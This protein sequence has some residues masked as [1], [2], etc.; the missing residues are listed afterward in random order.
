LI[1]VPPLENKYLPYD[2]GRY[3]PT[4]AE[5]AITVGTCMGM[6]LLYVLFAKFVPMI[7]IWELKGPKHAEPLADQ[8]Q[9]AVSLT[10]VR[11]GS[12]IPSADS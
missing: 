2:W 10:G 5:I 11:L 7:S 6:I 8:A 1:V 12:T 3:S 9:S 4:W